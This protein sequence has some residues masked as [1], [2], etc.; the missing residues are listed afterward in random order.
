MRGGNLSNAKSSATSAICK[1][2][3]LES[4]EEGAL[5]LFPLFRRDWLMIKSLYSIIGRESF[6]R[7]ITVGG[8]ALAFSS[9]NFQVIDVI[10]VNKRNT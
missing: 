7:S 1:V 9:R 5:E 2:V 3:V 6:G 10:S 4:D 8:G